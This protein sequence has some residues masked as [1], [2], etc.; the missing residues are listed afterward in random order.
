M[1][2]KRVSVTDNLPSPPLDLIPSPCWSHQDGTA[3]DDY[4]SAVVPAE[5][6]SVVACGYTFGSYSGSGA[7]IYDFVAVKL[8]ADGAEVWSWQV[9]DKGSPSP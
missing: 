1:R 4:L 9:I 3:E 8:D 7:G 6:G 5:D 2:R